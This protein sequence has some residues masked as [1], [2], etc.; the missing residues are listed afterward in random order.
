MAPPRGDPLE[1]NGEVAENTPN[2]SIV[3]GGPRD[4][5]TTSYAILGLLAIRS[6]SAYELAG[7]MKRGLSL[8]WPR[9]ESGVYDEPKN[10]VRH[11]L[12]TS[13]VH[14]TG[15]RRRTVYAITPR[16]RRA[17]RRWLAQPS[18]PPRFESEAL[19][20]TLFAEGGTKRDL[21]ATLRQMQLQTRELRDRLVGQG[22]DYLETGGPFPRRLHLIALT[23]RFLIG[24][25]TWFEQWA[26][27]AERLVEGWADVAPIRDRAAAV[28]AFRSAC[29]E[30][31]VAQIE[32]WGASARA[33]AGGG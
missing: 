13:V 11:G 12:A 20:R 19:V 21:L 33:S 3:K 9:A 17:L 18:A 26:A 5:S 27:E 25:E 7:Q 8:H 24:M 1:H 2:R 10:L 32:A 15:R 16:G 14:T 29:G 4:L 22:V 23:G 30:E 6:W 28:R 31:L